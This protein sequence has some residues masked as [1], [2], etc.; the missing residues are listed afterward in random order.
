[1]II[2]NR[3]PLNVQI[4]NYIY[5]RLKQLLEGLNDEL[6]NIYEKS[7]LDCHYD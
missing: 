4:N 1:M 2:I 5:L 3:S 7:V 6:V